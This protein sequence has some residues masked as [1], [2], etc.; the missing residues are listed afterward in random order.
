MAVRQLHAG[1]EPGRRGEHVG[2]GVLGPVLQRRGAQRL[3]LLLGPLCAFV[4]GAQSLDRVIELA[5]QLYEHGGNL[6]RALQL[7]HVRGD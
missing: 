1:V 4:N 5:G 2:W 6:V 3:V 7:G